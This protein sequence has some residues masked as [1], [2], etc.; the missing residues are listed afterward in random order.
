MF[1]GGLLITDPRK[2]RTHKPSR[3]LQQLNPDPGAVLA[4]ARCADQLR[5]FARERR[6]GLDC[7]QDF[8]EGRRS[9]ALEVANVERPLGRRCERCDDAP[10]MTLAHIRLE[11]GECNTAVHP[12]EVDYLVELGDLGQ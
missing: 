10:T 11:A 9:A 7:D 2:T 12:Q 5:V 8:G 4:E 3:P 6:V 1:S